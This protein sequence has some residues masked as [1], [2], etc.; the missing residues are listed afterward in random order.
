[1]KLPYIL[2]LLLG[3]LPCVAV[4]ADGRP[5]VLLILPDQMRAA[6]MGCDGNTRRED[7]EHRSLGRGR[8]SLSTDLCQCAGLLS[9][10]GHPADRNLSARQRHGGQRSAITRRAGDDRRD[11]SRCRVSNRVRRQMAFRR[12]PARAGLRPS[13]CAS[14][15]VRLLGRLRMSSPSLSRRRIFATLRSRS[16][17]A[18]S[19]RKRRAISR[20]SFCNRSRRTGRFF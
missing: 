6:A 10:A 17:S 16:H 1:M 4:Y 2:T 3:L 5:N 8:G 13:R 12:R 19:S 15:R 7:A 18:S 14:S 20:W 11:L 9:G